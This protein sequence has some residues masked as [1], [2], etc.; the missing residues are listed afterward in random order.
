MTDNTP[1]AIKD[2]IEAALDEVLASLDAD[3]RFNLRF[4]QLVRNAIK[5]NFADGD[6]RSVIDLAPSQYAEGE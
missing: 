4:R 2:E 6:L 5:N 1:K 3:E